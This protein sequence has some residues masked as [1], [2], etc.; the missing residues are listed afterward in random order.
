M[1]AELKSHVLRRDENGF[2]GIPLLLGGVSGGMALIISRFALGNLA[3]ALAVVTV[4]L[5]L[6]LTAP[7]GAEV[8]FAPPER[9]VEADMT[10]WITS[11]LYSKLI[12][13][14]NLKTRR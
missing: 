6:A 13:L 11:V 1:A 2:A 7:R 10:E 12:L 14:A 3:F 4:V 8:V 9:E 5:T